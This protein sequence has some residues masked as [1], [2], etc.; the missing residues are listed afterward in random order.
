MKTKALSLSSACFGL[1]SSL[2]R[3]RVLPDLALKRMHRIK[4]VKV[5]MEKDQKHHPVPAYTLMHEPRLQN[6]V[7]RKKKTKEEN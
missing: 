1:L 2:E 7:V 4:V 5:L 6:L 3:A